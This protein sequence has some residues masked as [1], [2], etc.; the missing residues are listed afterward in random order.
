M[1]VNWKITRTPYSESLR[2]WDD[3]LE[4]TLTRFYDV[5]IQQELGASRNSFA[6]KVTNWNGVFSDYFHPND[7]FVISRVVN[8]NTFTTSDVVMV[9]C[10]ESTP[11]ET[12]N[13][14]NLV[15]V[16]G[17]D[18]SQAVMS[19][20]V[21]VD[22]KTLTIPQAIQAG[23]NG[24]QLNNPNFTVTWHPDN[25]TLRSDGSAF[26]VVGEEF[27]DK[28]LSELIQKY[29]S[30]SKTGDLNYYS[31]VD[32][33]NRFVWRRSTNTTSRTFSVTTDLYRSLKTGKDIKEVKNFVILKGGVDPEGRAIRERATDYS[34][35]SR[36]GMRFYVLSDYVKTS[37][38][39]M[40]QDVDSSGVSHM[41]DATYPFTTTWI[42]LATG[43][44]V[45]AADYDAYLTAFRLNIKTLLQIEGQRFIESRRYGKLKVTLEFQAGKGWGLGELISCTIPAV[46][47][48]AKNLR[49]ASV[50]LNTDGD[51]F[52][53]VEDIGSV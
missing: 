9:G 19:A 25:P 49:V 36:H 39:L 13:T 33:Q 5:D 27:F 48:A 6:F 20:I 34:S 37:G 2:T 21:F 30:S 17:H 12:D 40:K 3:T 43:N 28:P 23:L 11:E 18:F 14:K 15:R 8:T 24:L 52:E 44:Y 26:P 1:Y 45:T 35:I 29:S 16:E 47:D 22:A 32:S 41:R 50:Q 46:S 10:A 7:K 31:Y 53:L 51:T 42:S 38:T 4:E